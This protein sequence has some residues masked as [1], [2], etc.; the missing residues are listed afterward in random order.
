MKALAS[1][2]R[3]NGFRLAIG[4]LASGAAAYALAHPFPQIV[5]IAVVIAV[6]VGAESCFASETIVEALLKTLL[7]APLISLFMVALPKITMKNPA[8]WKLALGGGGIG[9]LLGVGIGSL[10]GALCRLAWE[11]W[12][13]EKAKP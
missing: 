1:L 7:C 3:N 4:G 13:K 9:F 6:L 12:N 8:G 2:V 11:S 5:W 10:L